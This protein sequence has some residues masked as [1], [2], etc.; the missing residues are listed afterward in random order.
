MANF[1]N[2]GVAFN[3][4]FRNDLNANFDEAKRELNVQKGRVD[5]LI[6]NA[7]QPSEVVDIRVDEDGVEHATA[8]DRIAS[9]GAKVAEQFADVGAQLEQNELQIGVVATDLE[10]RSVNVKMLGAVGDEIADD[11]NAFQTAFNLAKVSPIR[12]FVPKGRYKLTQRLSIFSNTQIDMQEGAVLV[13]HHNTSIIMNGEVGDEYYGYDGNG[14]IAI[15]GGA[16]DGNVGMFNANGFN[17]IELNHGT[18][19]RFRDITFK[20]TLNAHAFDLNGLRDVI[21]EGC[22]FLGFQDLTNGSRDFSEAIQ[23]SRSTQGGFHPFGAYDHTPCRDITVRSCYFG[24]SDTPNMQPWAVGVGEHGATY[25]IF[26]ENI[27]VIGNT[28]EGCTYAGIRCMK[29]NDV[30]ITNNLF[31]NTRSGIALSNT[32]PNTNS[33]KDVNGVERGAQSGKNYTISHNI[34]RNVESDIIYA[35]GQTNTPDNVKKLTNVIIVGNVV[36]N[37][38]NSNTASFRLRWIDGL[39]VA[40]NRIKGLNRGFENWYLSNVKINNNLISDC[41]L[42]GI[43]FTEPETSF[44]NLNHTKDIEITNNTIRDT[45]RSGVFLEWANGFKV[46]ENQLENTGSET[47]NTRV[48]I[49][50][51]SSSQNGVLRGNKNRSGSNR[52]SHGIGVTGTCVNIQV[53]DNDLEGATGRINLAS[54]PTIFEGYYTYA[55]NGT[56]YRVTINNSGAPVYTQA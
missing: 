33:S 49:N 21:I 32:A 54:V 29:F 2:L 44:R 41:Q 6:V 38:S 39:F 56:R 28:F 16:F 20:D 10:Q 53:H 12:V 19:F 31:L 43:Y 25:D 50:I 52:N 3:R 18:T 11:T 8:R 23:I 36:D 14:N 51:A 42:E 34:F 7:P 48:A 24:G 17:H 30:F 13:R 5:N 40:N 47:D 9:D 46:N 22:R 37:P 45:R 35:A 26:S 1:K 55:P 15:T 4:L 27:H